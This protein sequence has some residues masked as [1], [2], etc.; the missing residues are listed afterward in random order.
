LNPVRLRIAVSLFIFTLFLLLFCG[1]EKISVFLS[2]T[3][4]PF[5][6]VP[7]LIRTLTAP[8]AVF[9]AGFVLIILLTAIFGRVYCSFLCPL[10]AMQDFFIALS[11]KAGWRKSHSFQKPLNLLRYSVLGLTI[12]T[13]ALGSLTLLNLLDPYS[14]AGRLITQFVLPLFIL[15]YNTVIVLLKY[16]NIYLFAR[17]AIQLTMPAILVDAGLFVLILLLSFRYG[18]IYC[19]SL[20]PVG[21]FLGLISRV[22]FF[23]FAIDK[24]GCIGCGDCE[25]VCKAGCIDVE[26][27]AID[28]SRCVGCFN[29]VSACPQSVVSYQSPVK[30]P[31]GEKWSPVR[32]GFLIGSVA[33][34][35]YALSL[36][37]SGIRNILRPAHASLAPPVTPPGSAG[38]DHFT[39]SCSACHLCVSACPTRVLTPSFLDYGAL[40]L[41]QPK[42]NYPESYCEYECNICG[43]VC[44]TGA[45]LPLSPDEKIITQIG[46]VDLL[47]DKCV[48]YVN[49][50]NCGACVEVC[51][52]KTITFTDKGNILYP[53]VDNKYCIG[54]GACS[55]AC[56][57]T[58]KSIVVRPN[59]VHKKAIR[60]A[61]AGTPIKQKD[62]TPKEFPF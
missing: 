50:Q 19:N 21:A 9:V 24:A 17:D 58:P 61:S 2:R 47:K 22:S 46:V 57:T 44:P 32:R 51:P 12:I 26:N 40:G 10:G 3:L 7:A 35:A 45:I 28:Q 55:K 25:S 59:P 54:C 18:R 11:K 49:H 27:D 34:G 56:P 52:T 16:F 41:L 62:A 23:R 39:K 4:T 20:C 31:E 53:D 42:M 1:P 8:A 13:A 6:F 48:V 33:A 14:L 60:Q 36:F 38:I 5:Q 15:I 30:N 29:C 37:N 43:R